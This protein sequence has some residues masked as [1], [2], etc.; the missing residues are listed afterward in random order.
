MRFATKAGLVI[1]IT[2]CLWSHVQ[3]QDSLNITKVHQESYL[4]ILGNFE[5][6]DTVAYILG[7]GFRKVSFSDNHAP[8]ELYSYSSDYHF[9]ALLLDDT[10]A[11]V[12]TRGLMVFNMSD[13]NSP[14]LLTHI[15]GDSWSR[16]RVEDM[17]LD[18]H[19]L[20]VLYESWIY[21]YDVSD[22]ANPVEI[23]YSVWHN[24]GVA[25]YGRG[26]YA[27]V[28]ADGELLVYDIRGGFG[29]VE[30]LDLPSSVRGMDIRGDILYTANYWPSGITAISIA[31]PTHPSIVINNLVYPLATNLDI[32]DERLYLSTSLHGIYVF[33]FVG[34]QPNLL[35][36]FMNG[37]EE[38]SS[39]KVVGAGNR[40]YCD[41]HANG[42][43][44]LDVSD[45]SAPQYLT[46]YNPPPSPTSII[47]RDDTVYAELSWR[48]VW[49]YDLQ[50]EPIFAPIDSFEN[51]KYGYG[52]FLRDNFLFDY[53]YD[54]LVSFDMSGPDNPIPLDTIQLEADYY[55]AVISEISGNRFAACSPGNGD[56]RQNIWIVN[57]EDPSNLFLE[58]SFATEVYVENVFAKDSA[59]YYIGNTDPYFDPHYSLNVIGYNPVEGFIDHYHA[60]IISPPMAMRAANDRL[61]TFTSEWNEEYYTKLRIYDLLFHFIPL[62]V[63]SVVLDSESYNLEIYDP[64]VILQTS[65]NNIIAYDITDRQNAELIGYYDLTGYARDF[66]VDLENEIIFVPSDDYM[67]ILDIS[68]VLDQITFAHSE[69]QP[70]AQ[71]FGIQNV[72]PNPFNASTQIRYSVNRTGP[73]TIDLYN[74]LG[75][76]VT[77]LLNDTRQPGS[78]TLNF[79]GENL[80]TGQYF[81]RM[82]GSSTDVARITL[83]K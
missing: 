58:D 39:D 28:A 65:D 34:I 76:R 83:I 21:V 2:C 40:L 9:T 82:L 44:V 16:D 54:G 30:T 38:F 68:D 27:Y 29:P 75:Q 53:S 61:F 6:Q 37:Q 42:L 25:V 35:S 15:G 72:F 12:G 7:Y 4:G 69:P 57:A 19:N 32:V 13:P 36:N 31:N 47:V 80:S 14:Q 63:D 64:L 41:Q 62:L 22:P 77:N 1:C 26:F 59:I 33:D 8:Q 46:S 73:V 5:I 52:M 45:P 51:I 17:Y 11:Y 55:D 71:D 24:Y 67:A 74:V 81:L 43:M 18:G 10:I 66:T 78:Y 48:G 56:L 3:A 60:P 20:F 70:L 49:T 79:N 50:S 23:Y